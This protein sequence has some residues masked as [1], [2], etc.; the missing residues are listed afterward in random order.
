MIPASAGLALWHHTWSLGVALLAIG[1]LGF[2]F[3][4]VSAISLGHRP[5]AGITGARPRF[6]DRRRH[7]RPRCDVGA[8]DAALHQSRHRLAGGDGAVLAALSV[9]TILVSGPGRRS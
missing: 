7:G 3:S 1:V 4:V 6:V 5:G 9:L 2:E 8:G